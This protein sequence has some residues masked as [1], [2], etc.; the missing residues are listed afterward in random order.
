[1][2]RTRKITIAL[3]RVVA[4]FVLSLSTAPP[5]AA[6]WARSFAPPTSYVGEFGLRFWFGRAQTKKDLYDTSGSMLVSR[7]D[8]YDTTIFTGEAYSRLDFNNGW[9]I[10]GYFGGG[11]LFGGKLKDED[12]PPVV[13]PYSATLSDNKSGSLIYGSVTGTMSD[14]APSIAAACSALLRAPQQRAA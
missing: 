13:A 11:G 5:V 2:G 3:T 6:D 10:K 9:F 4:A 12:F 1:M 7:L 14:F 8:Y